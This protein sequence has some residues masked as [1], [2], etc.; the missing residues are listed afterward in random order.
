MAYNSRPSNMFRSAQA[1]SKTPGGK[2]QQQQQ[3]QTDHD[4]S[5]EPSDIIEC[6]S[7]MGIQF[8][9]EDLRSPTP[10][11][12]QYLY[13]RFAHA[14]MGVNRETV[15]PV[16]RAAAAAAAA[17]GDDSADP[18]LDAAQTEAA[19]LMA[20]HASL[21]QLMSECGLH[22]FSFTDMLRPEPER[23]RHV[24]SNVIN[25]LRF[26]AAK[27]AKTDELMQRGYDTRDRIE[28]LAD[29]NAQL[30]GRI[31]ALKAQ[32][33][34]EEPAIAAARDVNRALTADLRGC[35]KKQIAV[36]R[37]TDSLKAERK[38]LAAKLADV[39]FLVQTAVR[40]CGR[41]QPYIV[42]APEQLQLVI[43]DLGRSLAKE[44]EA[45]D[46]AD[47]RARALQTSADSFAV[48]EADVAAC[49][50]LM[51]DCQRELA[52]HDEQARKLQRHR[53]SLLQKESEVREIELK[54]E[55]AP[56]SAILPALG[57]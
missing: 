29:E 12:V 4:L 40:D 8:H 2:K 37:D 23:L 45:A 42:D 30:A 22:N 19:Q 46:A 35:K 33:A 13:E 7:D 39:Q 16:I 56:R 43:A 41:L 25:F 53:D 21:T 1:N 20:F 49:I 17:G 50:R 24:L 27:T 31:A 14:L 3:H 18:P 34:R 47:R 26:R 57:G 10:L 11:K 28:R 54:E 36:M 51:E 48:V 9:A 6:L 55:V 15:E 32:R 44:R 5:L 38:A 52:R